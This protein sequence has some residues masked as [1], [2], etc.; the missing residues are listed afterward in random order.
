MTLIPLEND[1]ETISQRFRKTDYFMSIDN[2][3]IKVEINEHKLSKSNEFFKHFETLGVTKLY[4]KALGYKTF[5]RLD[6]LQI[7]VYL[8][9]ESKLSAHIDENS[10]L[11]ID[12]E[13]A[14]AFCTLGHKTKV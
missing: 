2:G 12:K 8:I 11:K 14:E 3:E 6:A 4:L 7:E 5:L 1:Q 13:N 10:L 9:K